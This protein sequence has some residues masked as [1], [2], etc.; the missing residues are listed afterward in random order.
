MLRIA[1]ALVIAMAGCSAGGP[2]RER[3]RCDAGLVTQS[4]GF[5]EVEGTAR[6]AELWGLLFTG[7]PPLPRGEEV[8]IVWRMT[9]DGPL[10]VSAA[11]GDGT[12]AQLV[13]GPEAHGGSTWQRPGQEWGTG[14]VF[15]KPGCWEI[16]L[17]R[18][19][20][21]GQVWLSVR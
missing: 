2:P 16:R 15:P 20:G 6:D 8:K 7:P 11:L 3:E 21:S 18:T 10:K 13:W 19:R 4:D 12:P 14:F 5:P 9:G 17:S 1:V